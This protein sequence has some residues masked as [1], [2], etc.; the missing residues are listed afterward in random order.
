MVK[1]EK[2]PYINVDYFED[3]TGEIDFTRHKGEEAV[4]Q[5]IRSIRQ[6]RGISIDNLAE[7]TGFSTQDLESI[8]SGQSQPQLGTVMKLSKA[9]DTALSRVLSGEGEQN[10]SVTRKDERRPVLRS[11]GRQKKEIYSYL[12][13]C[14]EVRGRHMQPLIVE[15]E[16]RP[17]EELSVHEGEEFIYVLEGNAFLKIGEDS[18]ELG[19]GDSVYYLSS[20]A[21]MITAKQGR[22]VILA[23]LYE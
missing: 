11:T 21:H 23:V 20:I 17:D 2:T 18:L 13:L 15:L 12:S 3:L 16:E 5:R 4:G 22:A 10:Y 14:P 8:E 1:K 7:M 6:D 9:L 19:P